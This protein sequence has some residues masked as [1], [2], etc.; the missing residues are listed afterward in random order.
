MPQKSAAEQQR[1]QIVM[2]YTAQFFANYVSWGDRDVPPCPYNPMNLDMR[3]FADTTPKPSIISR[4]QFVRQQLPIAFTPEY[5]EFLSK[6]IDSV[7]DFQIN[8]LMNPLVSAGIMSLNQVGCLLA[9]MTL[10]RN[11]GTHMQQAHDACHRP[12]NAAVIVERVL[13]SLFVNIETFNVLCPRISAPLDLL[14]TF[15]AAVN[16]LLGSQHESLAR[17][18]CIPGMMIR[19]LRQRV[20]EVMSM[21]DTRQAEFKAVFF[22]V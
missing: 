18:H 19:D 9:N 10:S 2:F 11:V 20:I 17:F 8:P 12:T 4:I 16:R 15:F 21:Y 13:L 3:N 5:A 6:R 1:G 14:E 22:D 7:I